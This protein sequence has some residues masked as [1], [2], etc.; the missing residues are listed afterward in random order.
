[1]I[2]AAVRVPGQ[3]VWGQMKRDAERAVGPG[4]GARLVA[5][6]AGQLLARE[7]RVEVH[8]VGHSAGCIFL[9]HF[10]ST[11]PRVDS[12][13]FVAPA[14][15]TALFA[16]RVKRLVGPGAPIR[17]FTLYALRAD[18]EACDRVGAYGRSL[19]H[20]VSRS[21][22]PR[23]P[24]PLL[25]LQESLEQDVRLVRFFGLAGS[26]RLADALFAPTSPDAPPGCRTE[27]T[28]HSGFD[29][30]PATMDSIVRRMLCADST[31]PEP[32]ESGVTSG[33]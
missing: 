21:C 17:R 28:T 15:T 23:V 29:D 16:S 27:A 2:E 3:A 1:M 6:L 7:P 31:L 24:T 9:A 4:G 33:A 13:H 30:D 14:I 8:A 5:R 20:L 10:V 22:E 18:R 32:W 11:L 19:L 12:L 26:S 25:G